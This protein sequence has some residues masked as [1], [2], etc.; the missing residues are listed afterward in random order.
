MKK[1][2]LL[3]SIISVTITKAQTFNIAKIDTINNDSTK[4]LVN[5]PAGQVLK[6]KVHLV[7][8]K[9]FVKI[10]NSNIQIIDKKTGKI[11]NEFDNNVV[12][13]NKNISNS[14]NKISAKNTDNG[15]I[16]DAIWH[17]TGKIPI[18]SFSTNW[19]VPAAPLTNDYQVVFLFNAVVD[20]L[21][22]STGNYYILQPVLQWG[23][24]AAGGGNYWSITNWCVCETNWNATAVFHGNLIPVSPGY[25]LQ[26]VI[27]LISDSANA[28]N[29]SS[30]FTQYPDSVLQVNNLNR[31]YW[32]YETLEVYGVNECNNYHSDTVIKMTNIQIKTDSAY[33]TLMWT[34]QNLVYEYGQQT[35]IISNSS[36]NGEVDIYFH[37]QSCTQL[38]ITFITPTLDKINGYPNPVI[39]NLTIE[40][41]HCNM[42][43]ILN[44]QGQTILQQQIQQGKT[45]IDVSKFAKGVYILKSSNNENTEVIRFVKE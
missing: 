19:I 42:I 16:T 14:N 30:V 35:N 27:K 20:T 4:E 7:D 37:T 18:S 15:W 29:Y 39:N 34:P 40:S 38:G 6:S 3:M 9:H 12:I 17:N 45:S 32:A 43:E 2:L 28:F 36:N 23:T 21:H 44:I 24:S 33:P 22:G 41:P 25:N 8:S 11:N 1:I 10:K 5:T 26:G 13:K 31:S